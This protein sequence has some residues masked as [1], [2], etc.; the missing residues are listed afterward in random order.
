MLT[1]IGIYSGRAGARNDG[2]GVCGS[3]VAATGQIYEDATQRISNA[4]RLPSL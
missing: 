3:G 4:I 2:P 1:V